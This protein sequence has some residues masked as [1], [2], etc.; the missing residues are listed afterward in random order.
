M[1]SSICSLATF[2]GLI[3]PVSINFLTFHSKLGE[4]RRL[5]FGFLV[6]VVVDDV[7]VVLG[8]VVAK[9]KF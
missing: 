5:R 1:R 6:V 2:S 7:V 4:S 3:D 9:R 8:V